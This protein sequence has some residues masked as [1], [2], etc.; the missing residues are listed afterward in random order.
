MEKLSPDAQRVL[1]TSASP[2]KR[3]LHVLAAVDGELYGRRRE[4]VEALGCRIR[5]ELSRPLRPET[6]SPDA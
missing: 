1:L 5:S 2:A 3:T 6:H 4:R